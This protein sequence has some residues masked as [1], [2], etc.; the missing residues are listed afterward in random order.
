[1]DDGVEAD[2]GRVDAAGVGARVERARI[3]VVARRGAGDDGR[4][5]GGRGARGGGRGPGGRAAA[6]RGGG[7]RGGRRGRR[8]RRAH[9]RGGG[10]DG[11]GRRRQRGGGRRP[12]GRRVV[13]ED[14]HRAAAGRGRV[15]EPRAD[16]DDV[17]GHRERRPEL[18]AWRRG[19]ILERRE[20]R[21][22]GDVEEIGDA[23]VG[24]VRVVERGADQD[25]AAGDR[26]GGA[27]AG[28][29]VGRRVQERVEERSRGGIEEVDGTGIGGNRVVERRADDDRRVA[30]RHGGAEEVALARMRG[31]E[32]VAE[33]ARGGVED[34]GRAGVRLRRV[35]EGRAD[36]DDPAGR[37]DGIAEE[38]VVLGRRVGKRVREDA[39]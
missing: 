38:V 15:V 35:V 21:A 25:G 4:H 32:G 1:A 39:G 9:R 23:G 20:Q 17:A 13:A 8:R 36:D 5:E 19:G 33:R 6:G 37:G 27:E 31:L 22:R 2:L 29:D 14:V 26:H 34:G 3:V 10:R 11:R 12:R 18:V 16:G 30:R 28:V 24:G 7:G